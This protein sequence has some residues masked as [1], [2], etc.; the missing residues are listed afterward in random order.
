MRKISIFCKKS[1]MF[2]S[3]ILHPSGTNGFGTVEQWTR[4]SLS[5]SPVFRTYACL[6]RPPNHTVFSFPLIFLSL[7]LSSASLLYCKS[8]RKKKKREEEKNGEK[9]LKTHYWLDRLIRI[10]YSTRGERLFNFVRK[11]SKKVE[12]GRDSEPPLLVPKKLTES[13]LRC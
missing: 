13:N 9:K 7:S 11:C 12:G 2:T 10:Y 8:E 1:K 5:R 3:L 6:W 4:R